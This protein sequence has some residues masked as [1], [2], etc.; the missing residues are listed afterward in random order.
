MNVLIEAKT[1]NS[2]LN[3]TLLLHLQYTTQTITT[4]LKLGNR[5]LNH[6]CRNALKP[7]VLSYIIET[8]HM[9][10]EC[11][12]TFL[13]WASNILIKPRIHFSSWST[14]LKSWIHYSNKKFIPFLNRVY[15]THLRS[16]FLK[17]GLHYSKPKYIAQT[18]NTLLKPKIS[19]FHKP[20]MSYTNR[21]YISQSGLHYLIYFSC[22]ET[23]S[24]LNH[25]YISQTRTQTR[26]SFLIP[27]NTNT[28]LKTWLHCSDYESNHQA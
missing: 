5:F 6:V 17:P 26:H 18:R 28:L 16:A 20:A 13:S 22:E 24:F 23:I 12:H 8:M 3:S 4:L 7:G 2:S 19:F 1:Y 10:P 11:R 14:L 27:Q 15:I 21:G 25:A 9:Y